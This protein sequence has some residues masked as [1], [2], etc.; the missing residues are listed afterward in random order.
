MIAVAAVVPTTAG[1]HLEVTSPSSR[2]GGQVLKEGPCGQR[3][4]ARSQNVATFRAGETIT[5]EWNEYIDHPGHYR[6]AFDDDGDDDFVD[7]PC[8][9]GCNTRSPV[10][11]FYSNG[12]VLLDDIADRNGGD[13]S[14]DVTLPDVECSNC[15]LQIIQ[16]MYDKPPYT[17][18]GNEMYYQ[19][20]DL[21]LT[22]APARD[23]GA[24]DSGVA[25]DAGGGVG[26][27]DGGEG[28][29]AGAGGDE[30]SDGCAC[31]RM[32][33]AQLSVMLVALA[34][35]LPW[36]LRRRRQDGVRSPSS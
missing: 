14:V 28:L 16:V 26:D 13:Y 23:G 32:G 6:I 21:V 12:T 22:R 35:G 29:S 20:I 11:E 30:A 33:E 17:I 10:V 1:A 24:L 34:L 31:V 4:G 7:P 19:C 25:L 18:P 8:V 27:A 36:F 5:V 2:Y 3:N 9:S 15:T